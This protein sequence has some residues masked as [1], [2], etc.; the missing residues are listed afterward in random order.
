MWLMQIKYTMSDVWYYS[1]QE[2]DQLQRERIG[3][4]L[5]V[6]EL[7]FKFLIIKWRS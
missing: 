1:A 2:K 7:L 6:T 3:W 4:Y 5:H